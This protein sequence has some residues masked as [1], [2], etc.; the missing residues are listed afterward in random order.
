MSSSTSSFS[1][2]APALSLAFEISLVCLDAPDLISHYSPFDV[3][4][5]VVHSLA[6]SSTQSK[7]DVVDQFDSEWNHL[8]LLAPSVSG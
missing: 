8:R 2:S 7:H 3:I 5:I 1:P 6:S 4:G